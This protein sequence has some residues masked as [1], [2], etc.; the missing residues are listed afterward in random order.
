MNDNYKHTKNFSILSRH[1]I[2]NDLAATSMHISFAKDIC[3]GWPFMPLFFCFNITNR[4][5]PGANRE[6]LADNNKKSKL[7]K[8]FSI[9]RKKLANDNRENLDNKP[10]TDMKGLIEEKNINQ[11]A[12]LV[13]KS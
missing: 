9:N 12:M 5:K 1:F 3:F 7:K 4:D 2:L 10:G 8:K 6:K 11:I 13:F